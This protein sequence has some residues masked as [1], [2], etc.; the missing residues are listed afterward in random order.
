[1]SSSAPVT[2]DPDPADSELRMLEAMGADGLQASDLCNPAA[3]KLLI[4]LSALSATRLKASQKREAGVT[5]ENKRLA[6]EKEQLRVDL[7][8]LSGRRAFGVVEI[9]VSILTGFA[10]NTLTVE[11]ANAQGWIMLVAGVAILLMGRLH[12]RAPRKP[13]LTFLGKLRSKGKKADDHE[14]RDDPG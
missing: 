3:V 14:H 13:E 12:D 5:E 4:Q 11:P 1:L 9:P 7:A 10:I 8:G 2:Y 6:A